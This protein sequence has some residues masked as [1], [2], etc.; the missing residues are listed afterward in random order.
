MSH[1]AALESLRLQCTELDDALAHS[2]TE[3]ERA[4]TDSQQALQLLQ[5]ENSAEVTRLETELASL[6]QQYDAQVCC[7]CY[8]NASYVEP[9]QTLHS[10]VTCHCRSL[11]RFGPH[12]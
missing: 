4:N 1:S 3:L 6:Q 8:A 7:I 5:E 9:K 2:T 10:T 11:T 12:K